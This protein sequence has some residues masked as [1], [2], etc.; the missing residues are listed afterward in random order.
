MQFGVI[1]L[2]TLGSTQPCVAF[3]TLE[4]C[5]VSLFLVEHTLHWTLSRC[6]SQCLLYLVSSLFS[7]LVAGVCLPCLAVK[8]L[9]GKGSLLM[10]GGFVCHNPIRP[11][12]NLCTAGWWFVMLVHCVKFARVMP[13]VIVSVTIHSEKKCLRLPMNVFQSPILITVVWYLGL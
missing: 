13:S 3:S 2:E 5:F 6:I 9:S 11:P 7:W 1:Y 8:M 10:W 12:V 4:F